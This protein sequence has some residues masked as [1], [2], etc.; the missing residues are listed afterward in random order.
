MVQKMES[1]MAGARVGVPRV[2][3]V[4]KIANMCNYK[5]IPK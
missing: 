3:R 5:H 1:A 4:T 2:P